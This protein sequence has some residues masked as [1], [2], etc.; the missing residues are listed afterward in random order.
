MKRRKKS[1][2]RSRTVN[3][4]A[5]R[6][7]FMRFGLGPKAGALSRLGTSATAAR[8]A[9]LKELNNPRAALLPDSAVTLTG[10]N[11]VT[12]PLT[13]ANCCNAAFL[14]DDNKL[15]DFP[16]DYMDILPRELA[17][18]LI[19]QLEP[20]VGF[21]ERLVLFWSNH[22][23]IYNF[24][25]NL[26]RAT[27]GNLERNVIRTHVLG[28]FYDMLLGVTMH[29]AMLTYLDNI[30]SVGPNSTLG[31][32]RGLTYNEN[33]AREILELHTVGVNGGYSQADVTS[34]A[35]VLTGWKVSGSTGTAI[36]ST[37]PFLFDPDFHEPGSFVVMGNTFVEQAN[38]VNQGIAVLRML[39]THPATAQHIAYKLLRHFVNDTPDSGDVAFVAR[40]FLRSG[41]NLLTVAKALL[42]LPSV[43]ST[44]MTRIRQPHPWLVSMA[45]ALAIPPAQVTANVAR[46]SAALGHMGQAPFGRLTPDGYPD[47]DYYWF[48]PD[49]VR[50]RKD[51]ALGFVANYLQGPVWSAGRPPDL[52]TSLLGTAM[53]ADSAAVVAS[54]SKD[55]RQALALLFS[56]PEYLRR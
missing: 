20:E 23:S 29:P 27:V 1:S 50:L 42:A 6:V 2:P 48:N 26:T 15:N 14:K 13:I 51:L 24:K 9:C 17:A 52:A 3:A 56:T 55:D 44:Q 37:G 12:Y 28:N 25:S 46:Y 21:V 4:A 11:G 54:F 40:Y 35:K 10:S 19:K 30:K 47:D 22:F 34:F 33:L 39:A 41:G 36:A 8:D 5:A 18:R 53:S 16:I 43:W 32:K 31:K 7:A 49:A 38:G 45:R